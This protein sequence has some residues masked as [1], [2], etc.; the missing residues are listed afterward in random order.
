MSFEFR[1]PRA[2][3]STL[4]SS[5]NPAAD[6]L[7]NELVAKPGYHLDG[8]AALVR[9]KLRSGDVH[10]AAFWADRL[11]RRGGGRVD[12]V[13]LAGAV[14]L[15][16]GD[17]SG[18]LRRIQS[19]D[20]VLAFDA[21][22]LQCGL[23]AALGLAYEPGVRDFAH[24][25]ARLGAL[26]ATSMTLLDSLSETVPSRPGWI[27]VTE[28]GDLVGGLRI[29]DAEKA[30]ATWRETGQSST[31]FG[32]LAMAEEVEARDAVVRFRIPSPTLPR[33]GRLAIT[34]NGESLTGSPIDLPVRPSVIGAIEEEGGKFY[35]WAWA[36][37]RPDKTLSVRLVDQA[38]N[39]ATVKTGKYSARANALGC[40]SLVC[41]FEIV[42]DKVK[43]VP[44][45][46]S[47][48]VMGVPLMGSPLPLYGAA[49]TNEALATFRRA[50]PAH[51]R[52][53]SD[54]A[55]DG[56]AT[57]PFRAGAPA[58]RPPTPTNR[59]GRPQPAVLIPVYDGRAETLA[60]L[61]SVLNTIAPGTPLCVVDDASPDP[62]LSEDLMSY[63]EAG[64][65]ILLRN[66]VNLGFQRAV[67]RGLAELQGRDIALL[68][69][70]A[71]VANDWLDRLARACHSE[72]DIG[73]VTALASSGS[74]ATYS[75][76]SKA[77]EVSEVASIDAIA[78][79]VNAGLRVDLPTGVGHCLY[80]RAGC[81]AEVGALDAATYG[82]GYGEENDFCLR[83]RALG[84]RNIAAP[85]VFVGHL[86]ERSF[87]LRRRILSDR[88]G[89]IIERLYPGYDRVVAEHIDE[90]PL[91][92]ARRRIDLARTTLG[93]PAQ[94]LVT[95]GLSGGVATRL[96]AR[97]REL[98]SEGASVWTLRS[99]TPKAGQPVGRSRV[100]LEDQ[101][102]LEDLIFDPEEFD[103]L[104]EFLRSAAITKVEIHHLLHHDPRVLDLPRLL[105]VPFE[106]VVHDY[107]WI[108]PRMSLIDGSGRYCGVPEAMTCEHCVTSYGRISEEDISVAD[109]RTR[110]GTLMQDADRVI[111]PAQDVAARLRPF[112]PQSKFDV[113]PW[114]D[115]RPA[116][117]EA[118]VGRPKG[119]RLR[120]V[121]LG[122]IG[123]HKGFEVLEACARD[124]AA[125]DLP[126]EFVLIGYSENDDALLATKRVFVT[127]EYKSDEIPELLRLSGAEVAMLPSVCPETWSFSLSEIWQ[128]GLEALAFDL[129]A[130][131]ERIRAHGGG[132]LVPIDARPADL[133][134]AL[135]AWKRTH[136]VEPTVPK[137][138]TKR[139]QSFLSVSPVSST[140][141]E[142]HMSDAAPVE[143]QSRYVSSTQLLGLSPGL[144][145]LV[146][147]E[148][149]RRQI[150]GETELPALHVATHPSQKGAK[151]DFLCS[152]GSPWLS[153]PG[154]AM[155]ILV[156]GGQAQL[157]FTSVKPNHDPDA[158][159]SIN[160]Q[161]LNATGQ[162]VSTGGGSDVWNQFRGSFYDQ[163]AAQRGRGHSTIGPAIRRRGTSAES[164]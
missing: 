26:D 70:D 75:P 135:L 66:E 20:S 81:L 10:E 48:E 40:P 44:G 163:C 90:N 34:T 46:V 148:N 89:R 124:A 116:P 113:V 143:S 99:L 41:G 136:I 22:A 131:A 60:C 126:L 62:E 93:R 108:C 38:G 82:L 151:V 149:N 4:I 155:A 61:S 74:I 59:T 145:T 47:V 64:A 144:Y 65:I 118:M 77:S 84:W 19:A 23:R 17:Y 67:N 103:A 95:M 91:S 16:G 52:E 9:L 106:V 125:R 111:V 57:V 92:K 88:N 109:L 156:S 129:G 35:G 49:E 158:T 147:T 79:E 68:N 76:K 12:Y 43:L 18:A 85:D 100:I 7:A 78:R 53:M 120:V 104:V 138:P 86:G 56:L 8:V 32:V 114:D 11:V 133:N 160:L 63:A 134:D 122:A 119:G 117:H 33:G 121:V 71:L 13:A 142:I 159:I 162:I 98:Q 102:E 25:L 96:E 36:P 115:Q 130:I 5:E 73:T 39:A 28:N 164:R 72:P 51:L 21:I 37:G 154:H 150:V 132:R 27:S 97:A 69:A 80:I 105:G 146:V 30:F 1:D 141:R 58:R 50:A 139:D 31:K 54:A 127:G 101:S 87:G 107:G 83:A 24:R 42:V 14:C 15:A 161:R 94:L 140:Q 123:Q 55:L 3:L 137:T 45:P 112:A 110:S 29:H 153:Q 6:R 2:A 128:F 152:P 157:A